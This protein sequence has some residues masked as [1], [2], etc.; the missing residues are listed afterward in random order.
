MATNLT[1]MLLL[2]VPNDNSLRDT[3]LVI[4]AIATIIGAL[5]LFWPSGETSIC[6]CFLD[7]ENYPREDV[8]MEG[9]DGKQYPNHHGRSFV[10]SKLIGQPFTI[11]DLRTGQLLTQVRLSKTSVGSKIIL[12]VNK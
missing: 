6:V 5:R 8:Y 10:S 9:P 3:I 12:V 4:A 2:M 7:T 11:H 1:G